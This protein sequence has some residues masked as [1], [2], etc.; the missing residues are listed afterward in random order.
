[1]SQN[2][3]CFIEIYCSRGNKHVLPPILLSF[4]HT[5]THRHHMHRMIN[6]VKKNERIRQSEV[7]EEAC[8]WTIQEQWQGVSIENIDALNIYNF[9]F[10]FIHDF[11]P[12]THFN[13]T[14]FILN[15][16]S[17]YL[18][19]GLDFSPTEQR[20]WSNDI[21]ILYFWRRWL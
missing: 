14:F 3:W 21:I 9:K 16:F 2:L 20:R 7:N 12:F 5:C 13:S 10:I 15:L 17:V 1:M 18:A 11:K 19:I 6:A 4:S 8:M